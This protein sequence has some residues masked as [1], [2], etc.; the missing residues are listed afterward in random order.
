M[1]DEPDRWAPPYAE[2]GAY[3]VTFHAEARSTRWRWPATSA[4]PVS[5]WPGDQPG[6]AARAVPG[7]PARVRHPAGHD[8]R[9]R[10]RRAG[11][12]PGGAGQGPPGAPAGGERPSGCASRSR[13]ATARRGAGVAPGGSEPP[14]APRS[15]RWSR[16]IITAGPRHVSM[17][18]WQR[19][20][21]VWRT[22]LP[23]PNPGRG[24]GA[25]RLP[26]PASGKCRGAGRRCRGWAAAGMAA[27]AAHR[28]AAVT[29]KF[30][31]SVDGRS[32]AADGSS[33]W[34]TSEAARADVHRRALPRMP[35][36][37]APARCSSTTPCL[38]PG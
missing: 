21:D 25:S 18:L 8:D 17:R 29:W 20:F 14:A 19:C 35:S 38:P 24:R 9:A 10:V 37:S 3:N 32:A 7:H 28:I 31:T 16:A 6:H 1:I 11:L 5:G 4:R 36:S 15:S 23:I 22:R 27:Q 13:A 34:I 26:R 12:H 2:A 30:A 33:Q